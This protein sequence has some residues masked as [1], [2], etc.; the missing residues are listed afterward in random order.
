MSSIRRVACAISLVTLPVCVEPPDV[1][2]APPCCPSVEE[3]VGSDGGDVAPAEPGHIVALDFVGSPVPLGDADQRRVVATPEVFVD[4]IPQTIGFRVLARTGDVAAG[5]PA[6][7]FGTVVDEE[8]A[9]VVLPSGSP[10]VSSK[11]DLTTLHVRGS[12]LFS[13]THV[14]EVPGALWLATLDATALDAPAHEAE[15]YVEGRA[16]DLTSEGGI[17]KPC[18]GS[19]TPWNTHLGAEEFP[20]DARAF[21]D[22]VRYADLSNDTRG[23]LRF[24]GFALDDGDDALPLAR[25]R[26]SPYRYG[27]AF[28]V[29]VDDDGGA[30]FEKHLAMGRLSGEAALVMPD[31]RTVYLTDDATKG[32]LLMFVADV[33]RDLSSGH[34]F[35]ARFDQEDA[36]CGGAAGV[37]W[38]PLGHADATTVRAAIDD[39]VVFSDLFD[40]APPTD[41]FLGTC[42]E[43]FSAVFVDAGFECLALK[44]EAFT[45]AS[46]LETKRVAALIGA[47]TEFRKE[48]GLAYDEESRALYVAMTAIE[49]AMLPSSS[50]DTGGPDHVRLDPNACGV[51]YRL[52]TAPDAE[53]ESDFVA[54]SM[55]AAVV[56]RELTY[57]SGHAFAGSTCDVEGIANPD[58]LGFVDGTRT[59][60]IAE[61]TGAKKNPA[62]FAF[63]VVDGTLTRLLT[64]PR[65]SEVTG[66]HV[67]RDAQGRRWIVAVMQHP[68]VGVPG[69]TADDLRG[70]VGVLGPIVFP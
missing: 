24:F 57:P 1:V 28:E 59:L 47:T 33:A 19:L 51:V 54:Q 6:L 14:E 4:G 45:L 64:G 40:A 22:A 16:L 63:D 20:P 39:G 42:P 12:R 9:A 67:A 13:L 46:R 2:V 3:P 41:A 17:W 38:L 48:E 43:G 5:S 7:P 49:R 69:A 31:E 61:D 53:I 55:R 35:A 26:F 25:A 70:V 32:V 68:M 15:P 62:L 8:G 27:Y 29:A 37:T 34:L 66:T 65:G 36:T 58:N 21:E 60:L 23:M 10:F 52:D 56:G 30:V 50:Y 11:L 44:D 18:A